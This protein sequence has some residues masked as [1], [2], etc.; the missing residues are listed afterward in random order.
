MIPQKP[1]TG[2]KPWAVVLCK[3]K[4]QPEEP[5]DLSFF[6]KWITRGNNGVND[7]F[8]DVSYGKCNLDGSQVFGWFDLPYSKAQDS[9]NNRQQRI[10]N[11]ATAV[12]DKVDFTPFYGICIITNVDQDSGAL[13]P[14]VISIHLNNKDK[15]YGVVV[16]GPWGWQPSVACQEMAHGFNL[17]TH[18]RNAAN[19][20]KDYGNP[21]DIMSTLS[22]C[23]MFTDSR[24]DFS[25]LTYDYCGP[26]M[27]TPNL[28]EFGWIDDNRICKV[29]T[30]TYHN[31]L[32]IN[33]VAKQTFTIQLSAVDHP[34]TNE[35]LCATI[36]TNS[37]AIGP[38]TYYFEYRTSDGWDRAIQDCVIIQQARSDQYNYLV[39]PTQYSNCLRVGETYHDAEK[40]I[41]ITVL[42]FSNHLATVQITLPVYQVYKTPVAGPVPIDWHI[43]EMIAQQVEVAE[44]SVQN[45]R[46]MLKIITE[47]QRIGGERTASQLGQSRSTLVGAALEVEN[48]IQSSSVTE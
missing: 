6:Q 46:T 48:R 9:T 20:T 28:D 35:Y 34:E 14:G 15:D 25:G 16:L 3:F 43:Y 40:D 8:N 36:D 23:Y 29:P 33:F 38:F 24:Y 5:H 27:N 18:T 44:R 12:Q 19:P 32:G 2:S 13:N 22:N 1:F 31:A 17:S 42:G 7:F 30:V 45:L 39:F 37:A 11:A 41:T 47:Q 10:V 4:D 26:G 21:F